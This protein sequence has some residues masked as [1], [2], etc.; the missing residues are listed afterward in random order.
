MA[1]TTTTPSRVAAT[2]TITKVATTTITLWNDGAPQ[3]RLLFLVI[4]EALNKLHYSNH[5]NNNNNSEER[6]CRDLFDCCCCMQSV[7]NEGARWRLG[8][9]GRNYINYPKMVKRDCKILH[10]LLLLLLL[11]LVLML[12]FFLLLLLL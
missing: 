8:R 9:F 5:N 3:M 11:F 6:V 1:A 12:M 10:V 2:T 4:N 7:I